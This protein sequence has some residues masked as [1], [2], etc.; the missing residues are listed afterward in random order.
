MLL[1]WWVEFGAEEIAEA[2]EV[3]AGV[4]IFLGGEDAT[5]RVDDGAVGAA[6]GGGDGSER[7][8]REQFAG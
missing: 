7:E 1:W 3:G 4:R 6:K 8:V 5:A 2:G